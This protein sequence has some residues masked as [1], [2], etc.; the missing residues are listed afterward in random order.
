MAGFRRIPDTEPDI[1]SIPTYYSNFEA[2]IRQVLR[3]KAKQISK[4]SFLDETF[5]I[6]SLVPGN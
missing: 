1:R 2:N 4:E 6:E 5:E 3:S